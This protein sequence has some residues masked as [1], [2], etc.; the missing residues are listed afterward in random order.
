MKFSKTKSALSTSMAAIFLLAGC[1]PVAVNNEAKPATQRGAFFSK[2]DEVDVS[3]KEAFAK[4]KK[5]AVPVFR[6]AFASE[7]GAKSTAGGGLGGSGATV[8]AKTKLIGAD[9]KNL[10]AIT[11]K[12]YA[13][14]IS[15]L[16][17]NGYTV[18]DASTITSQPE[19][20]AIDSKPNG[21]LNDADDRRYFAPTGQKLIMQPGEGGALSGFAALAGNAPYKKLGE[22]AKKNGDVSL[23][24]VTYHINYLNTEGDSG[25]FQM[26]ANVEIGAGL[27]VAPGSKITLFSKDALE[28]VGYC[29]NTMPVAKLGQAVYSTEQF[30]ELKDTTTDAER[31]GQYALAALATFAGV[32]KSSSW[33]FDLTVDPVKFESVASKVIAQTNEKLI[34]AIK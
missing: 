34:S 24:D 7:A 9:D 33:S 23:L 13:N 17:A 28:C 29:P 18:V 10:Q 21:S 4:A 16:K 6:V 25:F 2:A 3:G 12:A 20:Q 32:H 31:T 14:F 8:H 30:G 22:I 5:V 19:Y 26:S 1:T 11:D 15:T 27:S